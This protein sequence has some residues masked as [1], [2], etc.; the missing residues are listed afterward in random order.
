V[1]TKGWGATRPI[2]SNVTEETR[3]RNRRV[4]FTVLRN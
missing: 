2:A 3:R 1:Q 4:E